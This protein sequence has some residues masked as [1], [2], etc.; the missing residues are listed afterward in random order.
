MATA[1]QKKASTEHRRRAS[2]RGFVRV[3]VQADKVDA[4]LIR[5]IAEALRAD[6]S[7]AKRLRVALEEALVDPKVKDAFDIF[8]SDLPDE[9]F[10]AVFDQPRQGTWREIDV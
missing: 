7:Q 5:A 1:S 8:G 6:D 9:A 10:D 4:G 3:E 2:A